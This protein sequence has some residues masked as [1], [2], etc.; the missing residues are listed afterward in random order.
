MNLPVQMLRTKLSSLREQKELLAAEP[1][2]QPLAI[3][4]KSDF[5]K[6]I[7]F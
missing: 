5:L 4:K 2:C 3:K 7:I 1:P 6:K